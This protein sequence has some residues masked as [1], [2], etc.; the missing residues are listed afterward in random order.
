MYLRSLRVTRPGYKIL[1]IN[2]YLTSIKFDY[3]QSYSASFAKLN[4]VSQTIRQHLFKELLWKIIR[5]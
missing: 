5:H 4:L 2:T 1:K 3:F